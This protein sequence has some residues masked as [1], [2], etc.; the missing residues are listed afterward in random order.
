MKTAPN[1]LP[2]ENGGQTNMKTS[3]EPV[4]R[5]RE[6]LGQDVILLPIKR[7]QKAPAIKDWRSIALA[8][9]SNPTYLKQLSN[10]NIG[11][12][13]GEPSNGLCSIDIDDDEQAERFLSLNPNLNNTLQTRG[14][15]GKNIWIRVIGGFP[16]LT[17]LQWKDEAGKNQKWGE[18]RATGGQTVI[19]GKHPSGC[20][21][22]IIHNQQPIEN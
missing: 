20:E 18:W 15:R 4:R 2:M 16:K 5:L 14:S 11:V 7:G 22:Q 12:L 6:L 13:L 9:M 1:K 17:I 8:E 19:Y 3:K 21:Y 10:G